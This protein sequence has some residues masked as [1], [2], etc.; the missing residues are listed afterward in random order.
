MLTAII[1]KF[2]IN[3]LGV[4]F[5]RLKLLVS[6]NREHRIFKSFLNLKSIK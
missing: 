1:F 2:L 5:I 3:Y 6:P 4:I